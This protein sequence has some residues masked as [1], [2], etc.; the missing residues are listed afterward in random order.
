MAPHTSMPRISLRPSGLS[1]PVRIKAVLRAETAST[2]R[3]RDR[4]GRSQPHHQRRR[5]SGQQ[6]SLRNRKHQ[7][8]QRAR[9]RPQRCGSDNRPG[10]APVERS[11]DH[12]RIGHMGM[13][14]CTG[15][16][17]DVMEWRRRAV[18][19]R[20]RLSIRGH[21]WFGRIEGLESRRPGG[22]GA[23]KIA[24]RP[25]QEIDRLEV[26]LRRPCRPNDLAPDQPASQRDDQ[27]VGD[28]LE[29]ETGPGHRDAGHVQDHR[30]HQDQRDG[31]AGLRERCD[32]RQHDAVS[33]ALAGG[34]Q[35]GRDHGLAM[36]G[37]GGVNDPVQEG[38]TEQS[39]GGMAVV[40][41]GAN[42]RRH[43][44]IEIDLHRDEEIEEP[45]EKRRSR[46]SATFRQANTERAGRRR[47]ARG[48]PA[49]PKLRPARIAV[50]AARW[51]KSDGVSF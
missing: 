23:G 51:R 32:E 8:D 19:L 17:I 39:P 28:N 12:R 41:H 5:D 45:W 42:R 48:G 16:D 30:C 2:A 34:E 25:G 49:T 15:A 40:A 22:C 14:A 20:A 1:A 24:P 29:I 46:H 36:T 11:F 3:P 50:R 27:C 6:Q 9:A 18:H 44:L 47:P 43:V 31:A 21:R 4:D 10:L 38:E 33:Q 35:I 37:A 13:A 7:N 26:E